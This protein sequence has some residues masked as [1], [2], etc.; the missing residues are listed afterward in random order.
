[1]NYLSY[2]KEFLLDALFPKFCINC[3]KE[4][5]YI[6]YDCFSLI[7]IENRQYCPFCLDEKFSATCFNCR[8]S[9]NLGKLYFASSYENKIIKKLIHEFKY[10]PFV[11]DIAK[12]LAQIMIIHIALL[13]KTKEIKNFTLI[14]VPLYKSK[15]RHRGFNQSQE[16][17]N[18]LS[19]FFKI[20]VLKNALI[21]I[22]NTENQAELSK[23]KR[24][25]NLKNVFSCPNPEIIKNKNILLVDDVFTT[26]ATME[27]CASILKQSGALRVHGI[28]VARG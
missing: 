1:M 27:E 23:E 24:E 25:K 7:D 20:P 26:G 11:K 8:K 19:E 4:G 10:E 28:V 3:Q 16:L 21:K 5:N 15:L 6:C 17:A 18:E 9:K 14:P 2:A 12:I 13:K 22:K